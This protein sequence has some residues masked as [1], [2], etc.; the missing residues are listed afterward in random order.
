M[1]CQTVRRQTAPQTAATLSEAI[2]GGTVIPD[3]RLILTILSGAAGCF[4]FIRLTRARLLRQHIWFAGLLVSGALQALLWIAGSPSTSSYA[5]W[6]GLTIPLVLGFRVAAVIEAWRQLM[7][8]YPGVE[9]IA[10]RLALGTVLVGLAISLASGS[11]GLRLMHIPA[12]LFVSRTLFLALRYSYSILLVVCGVLW[13]WA[14]LFRLNVTDNMLRHL[15]MLTGYFAFNAA[16]YMLINFL[17]GS[18]PW[19]GAFTTGA[20]AAFYVLWGL[21]FSRTGSIVR[22]GSTEHLRALKRWGLRQ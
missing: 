16:G 10:R 8:C 19:I 5:F 4:A 12:R 15:G 3:P 22:E 20:S 11:D 21:A 7:R 18:A 17:P 1:S 9:F 13:A 6:W 2:I 14:A